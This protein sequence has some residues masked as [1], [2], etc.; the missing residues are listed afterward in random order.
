MRW[1]YNE[2]LRT[3]F[4]ASSFEYHSFMNQVVADQ[5][6]MGSVAQG[7]KGLV[8][9]HGSHVIDVQKFNGLLHQA[10]R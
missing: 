1:P 4:R 5:N 8:D 2:K 7:H 10:L 9:G 3:S 6:E